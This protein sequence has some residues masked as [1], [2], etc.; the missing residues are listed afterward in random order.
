MIVSARS[1]RPVR[2]FHGDNLG[3][4]RRL[5]DEG[6][7]FDL[8]YLDPPFGVGTTHGARTTRGESRADRTKV[9][10]DDAFHGI[11]RFIEALEPRLR[12]FHALLSARGTMY[13][14]LD[15][16]AVHEAKVACD[17]VFSRDAFRGEI[18][19]VPGN[20]ARSRREWGATH[21]T[22][23]VYSRDDRAAPKEPAWIFHPDD[24]TL[25][26]PYAETST[27]RHF[28][29]GKDGTRVRERTVMLKDG[30]KT[31]RYELDRGRRLGT[32]WTDVPSMSANTPLARE[33]TGYPHQKPEKLLQRVIRASSDEGSVVGDF[34]CGSGT[35][36]HV[37][38][39]EGRIA[40][41]CDASALAIE[42]TARRLRAAKIEVQI[43]NATG[44]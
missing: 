37:A 26:E 44:R 9:A 42:T 16:R 1:V 17:R 22:M 19:W 15:H 29:A 32:V 23:L 10:Y 11:D 3:V 39:R 21:Q 20:G 43:E 18:V 7:L 41:G 27:A 2:L 25:R 36:L 34:F 24:E 28:R 14:H 6:A 33:T 30:P 4:T 12:A 8:L 5:A 35:T 38:A 13:L 40:I 31:Y